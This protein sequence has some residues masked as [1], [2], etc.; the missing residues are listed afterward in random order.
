[1]FTL[2]LVMMQDNSAKERLWHAMIIK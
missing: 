1:M 2:H